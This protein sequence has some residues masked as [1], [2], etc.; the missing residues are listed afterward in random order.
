MSNL[1]AVGGRAKD[2][3]YYQK[4]KDLFKVPAKYKLW[5][6]PKRHPPTVDNIHD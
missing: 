2:R 6:V 5:P 4:P 1:P 3:K